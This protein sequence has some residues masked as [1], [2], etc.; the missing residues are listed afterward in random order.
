[1]ARGAPQTGLIDHPSSPTGACRK[2]VTK[3]ANPSPQQQRALDAR[4][5]KLEEM[6]NQIASGSL[7]V[8]Q[9]SPEERKK[10]P[11]PPP[12]PAKAKRR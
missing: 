12:R 2:L 10:F 7:T 6:R 4:D 11:K 9:M 8:R 3:M 5:K 1:M